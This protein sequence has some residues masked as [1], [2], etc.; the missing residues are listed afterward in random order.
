ME[1]GKTLNTLFVCIFLMTVIDTY[2][3]S[4]PTNDCIIY[5][6]SSQTACTGVSEESP[7]YDCRWSSG[8]N[9]NV[10]EV[11]RKGRIVAYK[12]KWFGGYW[13]GW[14][15]PGINDIDVKY[16]TV[17]RNCSIPCKA[18]TMRRMWSYFYDHIHT[19]I[20]CRNP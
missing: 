19:Y 2:V 13:S 17:E 1:S 20:I 11:I 18:N 5:D 12:I 16:N 14:Y 3:E 8:L 9:I 7:T 6:I 4:C 10:D 15:V